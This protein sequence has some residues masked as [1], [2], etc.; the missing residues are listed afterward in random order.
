MVQRVGR[1]GG[2]SVLSNDREGIPG[3][4]R[5]EGKIEECVA[6]Y[7]LKMRSQQET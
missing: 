3:A 5:A 4:L 1:L 6:H 7:S 2:L